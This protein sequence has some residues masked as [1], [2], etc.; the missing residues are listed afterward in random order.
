MPARP[1]RSTRA[2][3]VLAAILAFG[4]A[5]D[6]ATDP[7]GAVA[8][9]RGSWQ[10]S[11]DQS[12]PALTLTG[13]L[14]IQTQAGEVVGGQLSWQEQDGMGGTISRGGAVSGRVIGES[15]VDF[16]VILGAVTRR[17]VGRISGDSLNGAWVEVSTGK[18]G[19]FTAVKAP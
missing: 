4:G 5:C 14:V 10:Y 2:T 12:A 3:L 16:D 11:G 15:D 9:I 6:F 8:D 18:S 13:T 1:V 7:G 19:D 17:H